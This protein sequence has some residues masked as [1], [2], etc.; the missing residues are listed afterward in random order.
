MEC[1]GGAAN[2]AVEADADGCAAGEGEEGGAKLAMEI[3]DELIAGGADLLIRRDKVG[4][5]VDAA[6]IGGEIAPVE[7]EDIREGGMAADEAGVLRGDEPI[8][9]GARVAAAEFLQDG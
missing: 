1:A 3:D 8:D 7:E 5:G 2:G 6:G 9:A 4:D